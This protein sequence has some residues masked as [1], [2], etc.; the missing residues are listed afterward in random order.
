MSKD[1]RGNT[2]LGGTSSSVKGHCKETPNLAKQ[3]AG[4]LPSRGTWWIETSQDLERSD[5]IKKLY[6]RD[7]LVC[8]WDLLTGALDFVFQLDAVQFNS[9]KLQYSEH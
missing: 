9:L 7:N 2:T 4:L 1:K 3:S 5:I 6:L 8:W